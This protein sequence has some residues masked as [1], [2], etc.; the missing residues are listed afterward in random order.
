MMELMILGLLLDLLVRVKVF[1][2]WGNEVYRN[3]DYKNDWRGK[4]VNNLLGEDLP[5][6]TYYYIVLGTNIDG[7]QMKL[8]G[9]LTI[10]R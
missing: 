7:K 1:N 8:A 9:N 3:A 4:G 6:G 5:E 10:K 2:R